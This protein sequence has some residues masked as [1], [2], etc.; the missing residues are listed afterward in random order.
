MFPV[1]LQLW[2]VVAVFFVIDCVARVG[3]RDRLFV[4]AGGRQFRVRRPGLRLL[5]PWPFARAYRVA[6]PPIAVLEAG[7]FIATADTSGA[8]RFD[9][10]RY[11][12]LDWSEVG[13]IVADHR[14]VVI[15]GVPS[16]ILPSPTHAS[17]LAERLRRWARLSK[18]D[19]RN[20]LVA[21]EHSPNVDLVAARRQRIEAAL[22]PLRSLVQAAWVGTFIVLPVVLYLRPH[23][24]LAGRTALGVGAV[25]IIVAVLAVAA[26]R[27]LASGGTENTGRFETTGVLLPLLM[28]P[29]NLLRADAAV[30]LDLLHGFDP[31]TV[32]TA[33]LGPETLLPILKRHRHGIEIARERSSDDAWQQ[34]WQHERRHV[35]ALAEAAGIDVDALMAAPVSTDPDA[36][37]VCPL[38]AGG[39]G[40]SADR[41]VDCAVPLMPTVAF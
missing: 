32:A 13:D 29:P 19:R 20:A 25:L 9:P 8:G 22:G 38:C 40:P 26:V 10:S 11:R 2:P 39:Y 3:R 1:L 16:L 30:G 24:P 31:R 5:P 4:A 21:D 34:W 15:S 14:R 7:V 12:F 33:L 6:D 18:A 17:A 35:E 37:S 36:V 23:V 27:T 28:S 41:C